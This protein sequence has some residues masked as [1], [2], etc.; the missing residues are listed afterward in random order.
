MNV[1]LVEMN[2]SEDEIFKSIILSPDI[3]NDEA[4]NDVYQ[5]ALIV[6]DGFSAEEVMTELDGEYLL[7][8]PAGYRDQFNEI[9]SVIGNIL[10]ASA[11]IFLLVVMYFIAYIALRNVM[12]SKERNTLILRSI[13]AYRKDLYQISILELVMTM[14]FALMF[15]FL[16]LWVNQN[17]LL[18]VTDYLRFFTLSNYIF[19]VA[20]LLGMSILLGRRFNKKLYT[21]SV[22]SALREA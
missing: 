14:S 15:V 8:Y 11:S 22:M 18:L 9:F 7:I 2:I 1:T 21:Q 10:Q 5:I 13:G 19:M 4:F 17:F 20:L 6:E 16:L 3:F 12:R